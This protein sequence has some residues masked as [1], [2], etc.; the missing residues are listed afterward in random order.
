[1]SLKKAQKPLEPAQLTLT[2][3]SAEN[4]CWVYYISPWEHGEQKKI[5]LEKEYNTVSGKDRVGKSPIS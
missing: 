3:D 1:M 5:D 4:I 2:T